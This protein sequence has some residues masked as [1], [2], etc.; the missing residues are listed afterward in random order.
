[1]LKELNWSYSNP[2][3]KKVNFESKVKL[4]GKKLF[5]TN[6]LKYL[7][8]KLDEQL[9]WRD[10][11]NAVAIKL[12]KANAM[13]YKAREYVSTDALGFIYYAIFDLHLNYG[14]LVWS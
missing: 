6:S 5:Q 10:H 8:I 13:L 3:V 12:N 4:N 9:N 14:N 11:I 2:S 1:M 7:G